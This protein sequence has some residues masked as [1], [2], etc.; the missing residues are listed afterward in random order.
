MNGCNLLIWCWM[1]AV[2]QRIVDPQIISDTNIFTKLGRV[3]ISQSSWTITYIKNISTYEKLF[4]QS[5]TLINR[6]QTTS[7]KVME[8]CSKKGLHNQGYNMPFNTLHEQIETLNETRNRFHSLYK[9]YTHL[10]NKQRER[11]AIIPLI[12]DIGNALF[13]WVTEDELTDIKRVVMQLSNNEEKIK[14]ILGKSLSIINNTENE[15]KINRDRLIILDRNVHLLAIKLDKLY[16]QEIDLQNVINLYIQMQNNINLATEVLLETISFFETFIDQVDSLAANQITPSTVSP[17]KLFDFLKDIELKLPKTQRLPL[18]PRNN[19]WAYYKMI[20]TASLFE[21]EKI[22]IFLTIPIVNVLHGL[23]IYRSYN[24]PVINT[25]MYENKTEIEKHVVASYDLETNLIGVD[26]MRTYFV[27]LDEIEAKDC[28]MEETKICKIKSPTYPFNT[29]RFCIVALFTK[30]NV[31]ELCNIKVK[32]NSILP[33]A[34]HIEQGNWLVSTAKPLDFNIV[35]DLPSSSGNTR[36]R[37]LPPL[38]TIK[39]DMG[40]VADAG[41][42]RL[43]RYY[44]FFSKA[45][46]TLRIDIKAKQY[47]L[48]EATNLITSDGF[49]IENFPELNHSKVIDMSEY[50]KEIE[51]IKKVTLNPQNSNW[52][53]TSLLTLGIT[54]GIIILSMIIVL[55]LKCKKCDPPIFGVLRGRVKSSRQ[56]PCVVSDE[57]VHLDE[58]VVKDINEGQCDQIDKL[59]IPSY[60]LNTNE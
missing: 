56:K 60:K 31:K 26:K 16:K 33:I 57:V 17:D 28:L 40:C 53:Q 41:S 27:L 36:V 7:S 23:D 8:F 5:E 13:G 54:L 4:K 29:N 42:I 35:C 59:V 22:F 15:V 50:I 10:K 20:N 49:E 39:L 51:S 2:T 21:Q 45:M 47:A 48:W 52:I 38:G 6:V 12:G 30:T 1:F 19:L 3:S 37:L 44:E 14:H 55:F 32:P 24:L 46:T 18:D 9:G 43:P 34:V 58:L 11:R 25:L